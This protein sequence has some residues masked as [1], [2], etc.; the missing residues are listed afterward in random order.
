MH[1]TDEM[2]YRGRYRERSSGKRGCAIV[3]LILLLWACLGAGVAGALYFNQQLTDSKFENNSLSNR[4]V[5]AER[6]TEQLKQEKQAAEQAFKKEKNALKDTHIS[7]KKHLEELQSAKT[8]HEKALA[9]QHEQLTQQHA[10]AL[11]EVQQKLSGAESELVQV[12]EQGAA[13]AEEL[14]LA[15]SAREQAVKRSNEAAAALKEK[16][17][18]IQKLEQAVVN[19]KSELSQSKEALFALQSEMQKLKTEKKTASTAVAETTPE[20]SAEA[21]DK[22][23][24]VAATEEPD[25]KK[26]KAGKRPADFVCRITHIDSVGDFIIL[27]AGATAGIAEGDK[28]SVVRDGY[29]VCDVSITK[30]TPSESVAVVVKGTMLLGEQVKVRDTVMNARKY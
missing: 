6:E 8:A 7:A 11:Q 1:H 10:A 9:T 2:E 22:A 26:G 25:K 16:E 21:K 4:L 18:Q 19:A 15:T 3:L 5:A 24:A 13:L 23:P 30:T 14:K 17:T 28:L 12:R 20:A 27:D 29:K